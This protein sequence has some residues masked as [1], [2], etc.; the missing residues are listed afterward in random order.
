MP[1]GIAAKNFLRRDVLMNTKG[2]CMKESKGSLA[3]HQRGIH[4]E[5]R[6]PCGQCVKQFSQKGYLAGHQRAVHVGIKYSC[7]K[8]DYKATKKQ[9]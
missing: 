1:A 3:E 9:I 4:E 6:N 5:V 8:C 2:Q 7:G